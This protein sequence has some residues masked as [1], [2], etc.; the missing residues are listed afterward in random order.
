MSVIQGSNQGSKRF[1]DVTM[2]APN[3]VTIKQ[4]T[5]CIA[6]RKSKHDESIALVKVNSVA[7]DISE[8]KSIHGIHGIYIGYTQYTRDIRSV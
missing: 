4:K 8:S 1:H 7:N 2:S 3:A 6:R 5:H